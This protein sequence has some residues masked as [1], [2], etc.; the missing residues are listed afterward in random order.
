MTVVGIVTLLFGASG[1]FVQ[2]QD[3]LNAIWKVQKAPSGV[4]GF[5]RHRLLSFAA[6]MGTGFLLLVSL[7]VSALLAALGTFLTPASM[8]G[9][10]YLW[11]GLNQ[12]IS[13]GV[14]TLLLA[15]IFKLLPDTH[16][17]WRDVWLGAFLTSVLF[18]VGKYLIGVYLG[19]SGVASTFGAAGS[20]V[21]ILVW[22][23]YSTQIVLFGAE[24]THA[25]HRS[26]QPEP[27]HEQVAQ[28][29][30]GREPAHAHA[31]G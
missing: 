11:Q 27:A 2:L 8:P 5:I 10:T 31:H 17:A 29:S 26:A 20:L 7:V 24:F 22:V 9:G 16:V 25:A 12:L 14:I 19:S 15:L 4:K 3:S 6:V 23:Y 18:T 28:P 30:R 21:L 13:L 1:V